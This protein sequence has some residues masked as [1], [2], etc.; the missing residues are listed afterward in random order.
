MNFEHRSNKLIKDS[1]LYI[2]EEDKDL[3]VQSK[4]SSDCQSYPRDGDVTTEMM[5]YPMGF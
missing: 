2:V 4:R 1:N 3:N 5:N